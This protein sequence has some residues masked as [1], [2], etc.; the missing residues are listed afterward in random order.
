MENGKE[1][2]L[3]A[4]IREIN[5]ELPTED[6]EIFKA[7]ILKDYSSGLSR[8]DINTFL[9]WFLQTSVAAVKGREKISRRLT[10]LR[11]ERLAILNVFCPDGKVP[12]AQSMFTLRRNGVLSIFPLSQEPWTTQGS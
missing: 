6:T 10:A 4:R 5:G 9:V 11:H 2:E 7:G 8:E 3:L 12:E 1:V